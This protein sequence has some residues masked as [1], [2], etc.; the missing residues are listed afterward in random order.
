MAH[1]G[2]KWTIHIIRDI[3]GGNHRFSD[4]LRLSPGLSTKVLSQ[5]L[6]DLEEDGLIQK[7][8]VSTT[9]LLVE[10]HLTEMGK[11]LDRVIVELSIFS[12]KNYT[13]EVFDEIPRSYE[14]AITEALRRFG[15]AAVE[16]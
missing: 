7:K 4:F 9:P 11:A 14:P 15:L 1:L 13:S 6:R 3:F 10:Y 8:V 2:R 5:R 12:I 16:R